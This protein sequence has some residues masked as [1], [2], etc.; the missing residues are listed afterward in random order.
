MSTWTENKLRNFLKWMQF[1]NFYRFHSKRFLNSWT[2]VLITFWPIYSMGFLIT[3]GSITV[4]KVTGCMA[5]SLMQNNKNI[6]IKKE[7][8][9]LNSWVFVLL[10][11]CQD[12]DSDSIIH[13]SFNENSICLSNYMYDHI[14]VFYL[15]SMIYL[16]IVVAIVKMVVY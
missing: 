3:M 6:A 14:H 7:C 9:Q 10:F 5:L 11:W 16:F 2:L 8:V 1:S 12:E 15:V 13:K 4:W